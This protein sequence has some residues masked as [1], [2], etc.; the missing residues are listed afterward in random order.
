MYT[1]SEL[2]TRTKEVFDRATITPVK[3]F[4]N[5]SVYYLLSLEQYDSLLVTKT[6]VDFLDTTEGLSVTPKADKVINDTPNTLEPPEC[7][8]Q[9]VPCQHWEYIHINREWIN[10]LTGEIRKLETN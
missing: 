6:I 1:I 9:Y 2:R 10:H 5:K 7:C 4:R 3:I 8:N